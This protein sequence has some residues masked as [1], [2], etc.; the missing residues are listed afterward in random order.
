MQ[1]TELLTPTEMAY[2]LGITEYTLRSLVHNGRIPHTYVQA[3]ANQDRL[4]RFDPYTVTEWMQTDPSLD[5]PGEKGCLNS[6]KDQYKARFPHVLT[7]LKSVDAQFSPPRRGKGYNLSKI[8]NKKYGFL[9]Y[10]RYIENGKLVPSR[11]NTH[12]SNLDAAECFARE[13][14][15]RILTTYHHKHDRDD[16]MYT[17]LETYYEKDSHYIDAIKKRGRRLC[18]QVRGQYHNFIKDVFAPF[19]K[20]HRVKCFNEITAPVMAK[21][22]NELLTGNLKPQTIN[23]YMIGIRT[24]FDHMV[25][26]GYMAENIL[27]RVDSLKT[28]P[29]DCKVVGCYEVGKP[30]GVFNRV[31]DDEL[32]YLLNLLIYSTGMSNSEMMRI[33]AQDMVE[34]EGCRFIDVKEGKT[35][36]RVRLAPLHDFVYEKLTAWINSNNIQEGALVFPVKPYTFTRAY[37]LLGEMLG[38]D[39]TA[40]QEQ[41]IVFYSG[42]HYW[43]TLLNANDLGDIEEYFMGHKVSKDVAER[44]NHRD[45]QGRK[46]LLAKARE[47]FR[48]LDKTLFKGRLT[49]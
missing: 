40:L 15:E 45:K 30:N 48:I 1:T 19:L 5:D 23:R 44:Y 17:V 10:V 24:I 25:R 42:R 26:D 38:F 16:K 14:R 49:E 35:E 36:N 39:K 37:I 13:N 8:K 27:N 6:L 20:K 18:E 43:K 28:K 21:F 2:V 29:G 22:Q 32:S 7:A 4:L 3:P 41:N 31:W 33:K 9:Y 46:R 47:M 11:W 12:T 34:I